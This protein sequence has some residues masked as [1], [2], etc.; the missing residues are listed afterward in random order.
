MRVLVFAPNAGISVSSG[1]GCNFTLKLVRFLLEEGHTVA[2][3]GFHS[4]SIPEL[5]AI[6]G[7]DVPHP[8][9]Q[10]T[11]YRADLSD[12]IY[13]LSSRMPVRISP[14]VGLTSRVFK[15]WLSRVLARFR[16]DLVI[17]QDDVPRAAA[18]VLREGVGYLYCHYP[19]RARSVRN[20]SPW[21]LDPP[22]FE[23]I[24]NEVMGR[25]IERCLV[26]DPGELL[27]A[28]WVN[29]TLTLHAVQ[30]VWPQAK[31]IYLPTYVEAPL[32][33]PSERS[34]KHPRSVIAVGSIQRSKNY[35]TLIRAF[36]S[37]RTKEKV[38]RLTIVGAI[39]DPIEAQG[40]RRLIR[41]HR[42][43]GTAQILSGVD[44]SSMRGYL[45][46]SEVIVH[47]AVV[48]PFGLALLEGM[49]HGCAAVAF[50]GERAG[51]WTDIID[52]G[53]YGLGFVSEQSLTAS[54][55]RLFE[56]ADT[57]ASQSDLAR[58]RSE[59]FSKERFSQSLRGYLN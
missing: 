58:R 31:P 11:L 27:N 2:L 47:P 39:R 16:Y 59:M 1:G 54:L 52:E 38:K 41:R 30:S 49:A 6:H 28:T 12:R 10:L 45:A 55:E 7:V 25:V 35:R 48:E 13:R 21:T 32:Q 29:S 40:L 56:R 33:D 43:E 5:V 46:A 24:G 22:P 57:L 19:F 51:G 42:L 34:V 50:Q 18:G 15:R 9:E 8:T 20:S 14:Y 4:L 17:F 36:A 53:R 44:H 3:A 26:R 23:A 37:V